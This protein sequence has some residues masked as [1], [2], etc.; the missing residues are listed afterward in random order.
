MLIPFA[1]SK[2]APNPQRGN[3][4]FTD[5]EEDLHGYT[6]S[7]SSPK[8]ETRSARAGATVQVQDDR[9]HGDEVDELDE[10]EEDEVEIEEDD[11]MSLDIAANLPP[12]PAPNASR[13]TSNAM[14]GHSVQPSDAARRRTDPPSSEASASPP[15]AHAESRPAPL[16]RST[17]DDPLARSQ[18][19]DRVPLA[20]QK[21]ASDSF[22]HP[23]V[24]GGL[25]RAMGKSPV[26]GKSKRKSAVGVTEGEVEGEVS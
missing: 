12:P 18:S 7:Y 23:V 24:G 11:G 19:R 22:R 15:F 20:A 5:S 4:D 16:S 3:R 17:T 1:A 2:R 25:D 13:Y 26:V 6:S 21:R 14:N 10:E 8:R 9:P